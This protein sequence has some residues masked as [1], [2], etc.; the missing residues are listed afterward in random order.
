MNKIRVKGYFKNSELNN[1]IT[2]DTFG[3]IND[4]I[5]KFENENDKITIDLNDTTIKFQKD[6]NDTTLNYNFTLGKT[7]S[8]NLYNLKKEKLHT[9]LIINTI[10]LINNKND[11]LIQFI[12]NNN[13]NNLCEIKICYEVV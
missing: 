10:K 1:I 8:D 7:T 3:T 2:Y 6:N 4:N 12:I 13:I 9:Y 5:I 11:I